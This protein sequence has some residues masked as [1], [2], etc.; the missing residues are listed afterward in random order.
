[1]RIGVDL[2]GT[3]I[4]V[5]VVD[6]QGSILGQN[7]GPTPIEQGVEGIIRDITQQ[8]KDLLEVLHI[9]KGEIQS[10]GIG[11][12]GLVGKN[13]RQIIYMPN[14]FLKD[15]VLDKKIE[16]VF[17]IPTFVSNDAAAAAL[18]E[19]I[20]G[21][22]RGIS[23]SVFITLGTGVGGGIIINDQIYSGGHGWGS[24]IGHI[25]VGENFYNCN[26][27][28]NGCLETFASATAMIKYTKKRLSEGSEDTLILQKVEGDLK[29]ID[30]KLIL[31]SAKEGDALA[32]E[33]K[34]R[35][36][37]YLAIAIVNLYNILD[38]E[39]IAIGGGISQAGDFILNPLRQE[40]NKRVFTKEVS[41]GD[42][43][44][45]ELG[46]DAGII[47]AAFLENY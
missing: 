40:V 44:L 4:K 14:L 46:N 30:A 16:K 31:D 11:V 45:A 13:T 5:G 28:K 21:S 24:E 25:Y 33:V 20:V 12:P 34:N 22:T 47:G 15:V 38:P 9:S 29:R 18:G 32:L 10:I 19:K 7:V 39:C 1:M 17:H 3:N 2:G 37:K 8:M 41:Y 27:G 36:I 43:V 26:C 42:I 35:F 23:N 6:E